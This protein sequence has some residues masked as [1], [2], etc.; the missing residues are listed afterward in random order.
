MLN[1]E[2]KIKKP[3]FSP[4]LVHHSALSVSY[5]PLPLFVPG[6]FTDHSHDPGAPDDLAFATDGLD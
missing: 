6:V 4:F 3:L 1:A 2:L 5:L